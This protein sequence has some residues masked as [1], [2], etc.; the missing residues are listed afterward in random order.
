MNLQTLLPHRMP[1]TGFATPGIA[2]LWDRV[3]GNTMISNDYG[4]RQLARRLVRTSAGAVNIF[5]AACT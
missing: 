2:T 5:G 1:A 4:L 3:L